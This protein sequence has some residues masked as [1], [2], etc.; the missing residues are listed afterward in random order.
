[1]MAH[2]KKWLAAAGVVVVVGG[3]AIVLALTSG[4]EPAA[5][6]Y[7]SLDQ[8]RGPQ[9]ASEDENL[10]RLAANAPKLRLDA[11]RQVLSDS[12]GTL[13]VT[14][15][16]NGDVCVMESVSD[17]AAESAARTNPFIVRSRFS[18]KSAELAAEQGVI[19]GVPGNFH[20]IAPDDASVVAR[21]N[22]QAQAVR[23]ENNAFRVP[24]DA[25]SVVVGDHRHDLPTL[26]AAAGTP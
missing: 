7:S 19:A 18:C 6:A 23:L 4:S 9:S 16:K 20:G 14:R 25:S 1:M 2:S 11:A 21:S 5:A 24:P 3:L 8:P 17:S 10:R 13:W 15:A 12:R 22:G 26:P